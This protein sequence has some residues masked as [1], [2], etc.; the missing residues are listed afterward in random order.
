[1]IVNIHSVNFTFG[2]S[3]FSNQLTP[4]LK[5][6]DAHSGPVILGGDFNTWRTERLEALGDLLARR[7]LRAVNF[8][9]D[10]RLHVF[11]YPLDHIFYRDLVFTSCDDKRE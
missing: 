11:G 8:E 7:G 4:I 1:M 9:R 2:L 10:E 5:R 6:I 3:D